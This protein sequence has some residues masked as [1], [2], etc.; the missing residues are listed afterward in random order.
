MNMMGPIILR[1]H[2]IPLRELPPP[3]PGTCFGREGLVEKVVELAKDLKPIALIGPGGIGKTSIALSVLHDNRIKERFGD[4]CRLISCDQFPGSPT[5]FLAHLSKVIGS[6][7]ENPESLAPLRPLLSSKETFIFLDNAESILD[8]HGTDAWEIWTMVKELSDFSNICLAVASRISTVPPHCKRLE[9]PTLSMEA[10]RDVFYSIYGD[11]ERS[12][13]IDDLLQ[14]LDFHALSIRLLA[15]TASENMWDHDRLAREW[16]EHRAQVL[17]TEHNESLAATIEL[18]FCSPTFRKLGPIAR[19]LLAVVAFFPQG[20]DEKNLDWLFP[21]IPD[22]KNLFDKFCALSLAYRSNGFVTMLAPI[23]DHLYPRDPNS[24]P[25]IHA[26]KDCYFTRLSVFLSPNKAGFAEAQWIESEDVN[27]E[28]LLYVFMSIDMDV[29]DVWDHCVQFMDHLYWHKPRQTVLG[30]KIEGL[31]DDHPSKPRCLFE[32]SRLFG[33]V[34]NYAGQKRLLIHALTLERKHGDDSRVAQIL[35]SLSGANLMLGLHREG[36]KQAEEA[37]EMYERLEDMVG[38]ARCLY[39]LAWSLLRDG[40]LDA[41]EDTA[42]RPISFLPETGEEYLLCKSHRILG[43]I[44]DSKEEKDNAIRHFRTALGIAFPFGW[45]GELFSI[46]YSLAK[47]FC[48]K[49]DFYNANAHITQAK[50]HTADD[51]YDLGLAMEMQAWIWFRQCKLEDA[52]DE[53]LRVVEIYEKLGA[54]QDVGTCRKLL[55]QIEQVASVGNRFTLSEAHP[56]GEFS[57]CDATSDPR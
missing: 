32:L 21:T 40:Q 51:A 14:R 47:V 27:V 56:R 18:S 10:A 41:A 46:H 34:G 17:R 52:R 13:V 44:Y 8:P 49:G 24:S 50:S 26:T 23:R 20:V 36:M 19:D 15:T 54:E 38:R 11:D 25:V 16:D 55:R 33:S 6:G 9:I 48:A 5:R 3:A 12:N 29:P 43:A 37:L 35:G 39:N 53:A 30:S 2:S 28:H 57:D 7:V 45:R 42:M 4:N 22:R 1:F 31:P